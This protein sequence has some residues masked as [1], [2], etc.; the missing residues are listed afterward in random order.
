MLSGRPGARFIQFLMMI[1]PPNARVTPFP[2]KIADL[3]TEDASQSWYQEA[4]RIL[5]G[6]DGGEHGLLLYKLVRALGTIPHPVI[7]DIGT[8]RGFSAITMARALLDANLDGMVYSIDVIDHF[9]QN[10]WHGGKNEPT[11]P[12]AGLSISRSEVW[13]CWFE[14]EASHVTPLHAQSYEVLEN[15]SYG[16]IDIAFIDGEHTYDAVKR[17]LAL[18]DHLMTPT[19]IIVLDDYHTGVS[20]GAFRSR[21][22]NGAVRLMSHAVKRVWPPLRERLRLGTGNEF[23]VVKRRF[24]GIYKAVADFLLERGCEWALEIV[25]MPSRGDY[26]EAD[27]SLAL[28]TRVRA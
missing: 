27:Y 10:V 8:A 7:L 12:L 2:S 11:E 25:S 3:N 19:G 28:L 22:V 24:A 20:M 15:W 14:E 4:V 13:S 21:P 16:S 26:H 5:R 9:S 6:G 17:E 23:L 18:L 1:F